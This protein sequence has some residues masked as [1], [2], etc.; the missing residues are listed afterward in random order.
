MPVRLPRNTDRIW[1]TEEL[2]FETTEPVGFVIITYLPSSMLMGNGTVSAGLISFMA[3]G[4][5][6]FMESRAPLNLANACSCST[7]II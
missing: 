5:G 3:F 2:N 6:M 7:Q 1:K 4:H